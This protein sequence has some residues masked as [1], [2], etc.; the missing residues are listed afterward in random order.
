MSQRGFTMLEVV[1]VS[2]LLMLM[3]TMS[4][5]ALRY[6]N[7]AVFAL[8]GRVRAVADLLLAAEYLRQDISGA[9]LLERMDDGDRLQIERRQQVANL[10]GSEGRHVNYYLDTGRLVREMKNPVTIETPIA[11]GITSFVVTESGNDIHVFL[12]AGSGDGQRSITL[13]WDPDA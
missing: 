5:V 8:R 10:F 3:L 2:F 12:Q 4:A 6:Q 1:L 7:D 13:V 11:L 9:T